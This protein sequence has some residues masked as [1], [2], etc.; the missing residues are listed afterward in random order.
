MRTPQDSGD[1]K[2]AALMRVYALSAAF[3]TEYA[4]VGPK[5]GDGPKAS[6]GGLHCTTAR[7]RALGDD[8]VVSAPFKSVFRQ[9]SSPSPEETLIT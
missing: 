5:A 2:E 4:G 9:M 7:R 1:G 3:E 6:R 8:A